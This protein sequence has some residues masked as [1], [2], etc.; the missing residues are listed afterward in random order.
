MANMFKGELEASQVF[1][2]PDILNE[3]Q[4]EFISMLVD[5]VNRFF[6]VSRLCEKYFNSRSTV[7]TFL[8]S[9]LGS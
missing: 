9:I 1:P 4:R 5:P 6:N 2:Y 8:S 3:E 7:L